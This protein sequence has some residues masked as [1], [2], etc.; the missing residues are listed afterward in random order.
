MLGAKLAVTRATSH[1]MWTSTQKL[2]HWPERDGRPFSATPRREGSYVIQGSVS[3]LD[4]RLVVMVWTTVLLAEHSSRLRNVFCVA[5]LDGAYAEGPAASLSALAAM[6][7]VVW[8]L[9]RI[10][11]M[12]PRGA[13]SYN[14][15]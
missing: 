7:E 6:T 9:C 1:W 4:R 12:Q 8:H 14:A 11:S 13:F 15:R 3:P 5:Y 10:K 2:G